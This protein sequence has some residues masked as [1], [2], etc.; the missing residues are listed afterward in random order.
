MPGCMTSPGHRR[1]ALMVA[2]TVVASGAVAACG[3][4]ED[5]GGGGEPLSQRAFVSKA[6][7]ACSKSN[8][9]NPPPAPPKDQKGAAEQA[10]KEAEL[11]EELAGRLDDLTP[12]EDKQQLFDEYR[13]KTGDIIT[14]SRSQA[15]SPADSQAFNRATFQLNT[16]SVQRSKLATRLG[17]KVCAQPVG[18]QQ[19]L[20][21][22]A[23]VEKVDGICQEANDA[24]LEATP[25][26]QK[27]GDLEAAARFYEETIDDGRSALEK[28]KALEPPAK[29]AQAWK[30][31]VAAFEQRLAITDDQQAAARAGDDRKFQA[32]SKEDAGAQEREAAAAQALGLEVC[33]ANGTAGI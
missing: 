19:P 22:A 5:D 16:L 15:D 6:D 25:K 33:G 10:E 1:L 9:D 24:F 2:L 8:K 30:D 29:D 3:D 31:F 4:D 32:A 17:F 13:S 20:G 12:P 11:R 27:P 21:D 7:A 18:G 23:F 14:A 26:E 28:I